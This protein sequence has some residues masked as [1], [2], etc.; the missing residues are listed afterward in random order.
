MRVIRDTRKSEV[1]RLLELFPNRKISIESDS[2][3]N[4]I[5]YDT[6][7]I[8][9]INFLNK[10]KRQLT[11]ID[12]LKELAEEHNVKLIG[13]SPLELITIKDTR[14]WWKRNFG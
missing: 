2:N 5:L 6:E 9:I 8:D 11:Q 4:I 7:D 13:I 3:G 1:E 12:F 14:S 10:Q